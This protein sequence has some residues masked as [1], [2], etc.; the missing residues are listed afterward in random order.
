MGAYTHWDFRKSAPMRSTDSSVCSVVRSGAT[1][2]FEGHCDGSPTFPEISPEIDPVL[3]PPAPVIKKKG[4]KPEEKFE[5]ILSRESRRRHPRPP[6][7]K[8]VKSAESKGKFEEILSRESRRRHP[9]PPM[10]QSM[11]S[12]DSEER[13]EIL[14]RESRR[15]RP[16]DPTEKY[17]KMKTAL[18][19]NMA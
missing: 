5:E 12:L 1:V 19:R 8:S 3:V 7:K 15:R 11:K 6:M 10:K 18:K 2:V 4:L 13:E 14:S 16:Q 9:R 17:R